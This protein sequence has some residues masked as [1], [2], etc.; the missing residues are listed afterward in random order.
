MLLEK[1]KDST[2]FKDHKNFIKSKHKKLL[3]DNLIIQN[4]IL[5]FYYK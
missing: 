4:K 3:N 1:D 5:R 2:F